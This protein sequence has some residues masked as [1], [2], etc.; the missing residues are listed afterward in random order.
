MIHFGGKQTTFLKT[1]NLN[2]LLIHFL[3]NKT[4]FLK[5]SNSVK[6]NSVKANSVKANSIKANSIKA[7]SI[8]ANS[9]KANS[10]KAN[11]IKAN[12]IKAK[13]G[14][15]GGDGGRIFPGHPG[16]IPNAP[17][18]NISRK[19]IPSLRRGLTII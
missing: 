4:A 7:N 16:P 6:A 14:D 18:D 13:V 1:R 19:G 10:I 9:I 5:T 15:G 11:S 17:R 3:G 12:S 2:Q 8:K